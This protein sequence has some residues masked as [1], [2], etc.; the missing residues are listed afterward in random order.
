LDPLFSP[1]PPP[2]VRSHSAVFHGAVSK[3]VL[4]DRLQF[5]FFVDLLDWKFDIVSRHV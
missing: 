1:P 2:P 4:L 3:R 5:C